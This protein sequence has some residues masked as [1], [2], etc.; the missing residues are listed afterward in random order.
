MIKGTVALPVWNSDK[1]LWLC[2]ESLCRQVKPVDEWE[3]I[4]FEEMHPHQ[5]GEK[6]LRGYEERL[7]EV[8][9]VRVLYLTQEEKLSLSRKWVHI[10]N[11]AAESS[12]Y[13]VLCAADNYYH[14]WMLQDFE[15]AIDRADWCITTHGYFYDINLDKVVRYD[16]QSLTGLQ[17]SAKTKYIKQIPFEDLQRGIDSWISRQLKRI[18]NGEGRA[19]ITW[20][21]TSEHGNYTLCTNGLNNISTGRHQ[22]FTDVQPPF[23]ETDTQLK[24]IVPFD[25]YEKIKRTS[26]YL[27]LSKKVDDD[28]GNCVSIQR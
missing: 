15:K 27:R 3:L 28:L 20:I 2:L 8:G 16:Y 22:F 12:Q 21:D 18:V 5:C 7:R 24:D 13:F 25:V 10:A 23:F 9:C 6:W 1:I 17:M 4:V 11:A 19:L 14:P 26:N